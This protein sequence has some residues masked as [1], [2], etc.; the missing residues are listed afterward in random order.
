MVQESRSLG[1]DLRIS[2]RRTKGKEVCLA[3]S[4]WVGAEH[5]DGEAPI[6]DYFEK[7]RG[8]IAIK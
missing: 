4:S 6:F 3:R 8:Y 1:V 2:I 5:P 7:F